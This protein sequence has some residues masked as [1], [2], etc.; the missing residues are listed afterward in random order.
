LRAIVARALPGVRL[1]RAETPPVGLP[2]RRDTAYF[3]IDQSDPLWT[4]VIERGDIG[5][6]LPDAPPDAWVQLTVIRK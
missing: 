2:R 4:Q 5:F 1:I 3:K 6:F